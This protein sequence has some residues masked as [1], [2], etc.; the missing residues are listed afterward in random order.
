MIRFSIE[1]FRQASRNCVRAVCAFKASVS[2]SCD[3]ERTAVFSNAV[4]FRKYPA[5]LPSGLEAIGDGYPKL[6]VDVGLATGATEVA[7][8]VVAAEFSRATNLAVALQHRL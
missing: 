3:I 2:D 5:T 1:L 7:A 6:L 4:E 8:E